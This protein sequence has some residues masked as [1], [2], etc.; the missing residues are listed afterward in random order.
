MWEWT[1]WG[2]KTG[3]THSYHTDVPSLVSGSQTLLTIGH[4]PWPLALTFWLC[5]SIQYCA[6]HFEK[7]LTYHVWPEWAK[8]IQMHLAQGTHL[9]VKVLSYHCPINRTVTC[10]PSSI[11][12]IATCIPPHLPSYGHQH[13]Y[14]SSTFHM[15]IPGLLAIRVPSWQRLTPCEGSSAQEWP[16]FLGLP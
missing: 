14:H 8:N 13:T 11:L 5:G 7:R 12:Q 3:L 1:R 6:H 16:A 2:N 10:I 4:C 9:G 15:S